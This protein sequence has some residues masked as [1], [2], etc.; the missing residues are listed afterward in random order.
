[1]SYECVNVHLWFCRLEQESVFYFNMKYFE[2]KLLAGK[3][4]EVENYLSGFCKVDDNRY[5]MKIFFEI[6]KQRYLEA[7]DGYNV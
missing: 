3:W 2:E 1:M 4:D 7:L 6:R 5:S